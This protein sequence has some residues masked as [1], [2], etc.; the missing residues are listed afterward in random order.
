[1]SATKILAAK[2]AFFIGVLA[3]GC[4]VA[5]DTASAA[6]RPLKAPALPGVYHW[7]GFYGGVN[8]GSVIGQAD[9]GS[10]VAA[11]GVI[12]GADV[13][14]VGAV[15]GVQ[16]G[17][18]W[19]FNPSWLVGVE[20]DFGYLGV[21]RSN[22][23]W[24]DGI[25]IGQRASWYATLR[26]RTGYVT[27]PSLLYVTGGLAAVRMEETF[28]GNT[29]TGLAPTTSETTRTGWTAGGGIETKLSRNWSAKTEY[30][31]IATG[32]H[33]FAANPYAVADTASFK[34]QFHVVKAG[35][36]YS[37]GGGNDGALFA[38]SRTRRDWS[39]L[40]AGLNLGLGASATHITG[41]NPLGDADMNGQGFAG[42]IQAGYNL[43][44]GPNWFAGIEADF[45]Y[46]GTDRSYQDWGDV[47]VFAQKTSW[48][49]TLRG[50]AGYN[51]GA[52]LLYLT[53]GGAMVRV[54]NSIA[55]ATQ[56][57]S[58]LENATGWT[59]GGGIETAL[60]SRWS[61]KV[62]ALHI[63]VGSERSAV[64]VSGLLRAV[65]Y[66]RRFQVVRAGLNY[67]FGGGN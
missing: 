55:N 50:R 37:F 22:T 45:N 51:T 21:K 23:D 14:S 49:G 24:F 18:N 62:E 27:G 15:G 35:L 59:V 66:D 39:G 52:A 1:M 38:D 30:L 16:A 57:G 9:A 43:M 8:L 64:T 26:A 44:L 5:I 6:D 10:A 12:A 34:S 4:A 42:G 2:A 48:Y 54:E 36:N 29:A 28:G 41:V 33:S 13:N 32:T 58:T 61:A 20:G 60:D 56:I 11:N 47:Y 25:T 40:Y 3:F 65:D 53:G 31:Y 7:T 17:F 63:D 46:L 19:Q 67:R